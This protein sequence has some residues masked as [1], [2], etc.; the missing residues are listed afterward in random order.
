MSSLIH[1]LIKLLGGYTQL[2]H[3]YQN[4]EIQ[5]LRTQIDRLLMQQEVLEAIREEISK[6]REPVS[7]PVKPAPVITAREPWMVR[8]HRLEMEDARK[9]RNEI[10]RDEV[11][12]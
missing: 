6:E 3:D 10:E 11:K 1:K 12:K 4:N 7:N 9:I 5:F 2:E 8:R